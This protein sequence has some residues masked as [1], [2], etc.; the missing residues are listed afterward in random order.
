[1]GV[2][3]SSRP[4]G[5]AAAAHLRGHGRSLTGPAGPFLP[6]RFSLSRL[7]VAPFLGMGRAGP[8]LGQLPIDGPDQ[9]VA[10][11]LEGEHGIV[12]FDGAGFLVGEGDDVT[13]HGRLVLFS[14]VF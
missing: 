11:D 9:D 8:S 6:E 4:E 14:L 1:M 7:D 10:A 5:H 3:T 13:L 2:G 12:K